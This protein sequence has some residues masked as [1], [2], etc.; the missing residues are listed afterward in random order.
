MRRHPRK[1]SNTT[2]VAV[3]EMLTPLG[4]STRSNACVSCAAPVVTADLPEAHVVISPAGTYLSAASPSGPAADDRC[5]QLAISIR[6]RIE[7]RLVGRIRELVVRVVE[8][9]VVLE[10]K[11][12]TYYSKQLAQHAALG[13]L[14]N[15]QLEN[16]IIVEVPR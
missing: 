5:R 13:V 4:D 3:R 14:E 11:C 16:A 12:A 8:G 10:G 7:S 1:V 6:Q 9:S 15:E 2:A